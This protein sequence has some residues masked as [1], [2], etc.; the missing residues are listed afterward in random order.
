MNYTVRMKKQL[1][2]LKQENIHSE[3]REYQTFNLNGIEID[4]FDLE[5]AKMAISSEIVNYQTKILQNPDV[6]ND[7]YNGLLHT[8]EEKL[9]IILQQMERPEEDQNRPAGIGYSITP[10]MQERILKHLSKD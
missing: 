5:I 4:Y 7:R 2:Q 6:K 9:D 1:Q 8:T 3:T 10:E